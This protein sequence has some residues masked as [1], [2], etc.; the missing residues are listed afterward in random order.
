MLIFCI[1]SDAVLITGGYYSASNTAELYL[2]SSGTS[3]SL[4]GLP[5]NKLYHTVERSGL[6]CGGFGTSCLQ[7]SS[8]TGTWEQ[9]LTL[10]V[11]RV[12]HVSWTPQSD[13]NVTYLM[14]GGG[15][16]AT[17]TT[18]L[19]KPDGSQEPGFTLKYDTRY[20]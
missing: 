15:S 9:Y 6:L 19:I 17:T 4:P 2:P 18:T 16:E 1:I 14:G 12:G 13:T 8:G 11:K 3:C 20:V 7:W 5:D 10:E